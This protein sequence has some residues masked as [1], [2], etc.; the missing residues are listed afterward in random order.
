MIVWLPSRE[1]EGCS[2]FF[3][4]L[5]LDLQPTGWVRVRQQECEMRT[6]ETGQFHLRSLRAQRVEMAGWGLGLQLSLH[7][8]T[9]LRL[10]V[11]SQYMALLLGI[12]F[13]FHQN[14]MGYALEFQ[15]HIFACRQ[16]F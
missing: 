12:D 2:P 5:C 13:H 1:E 11:P 6:E 9:S 8:P 3:D 15:V 14:L 4:F 10:G 7:W 16:S